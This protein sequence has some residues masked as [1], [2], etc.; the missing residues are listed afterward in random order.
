MPAPNLT[1]DQAKLR[2]DLLDV[3]GYDIE[4]DLTN[5]HGGR[6]EAS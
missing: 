1:R 5:G 2:A 4:L 3:S 6:K